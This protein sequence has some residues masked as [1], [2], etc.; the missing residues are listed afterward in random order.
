MKLFDRSFPAL[1]VELVATGL[2]ER[3]PVWLRAAHRKEAVGALE[4]VRA[5]HLAERPIAQLSGGELQ[6]VYL[7]RALVR[8]PRLVLLD[9]P[10]TGIDVRGEQDFYHLLEHYHETTQATILMVTH[11]WAAAEHHASHVLLLK[12]QQVAFGAPQA[13]LTDDHL[14]LAFGHAGHTHYREHKHA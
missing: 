1:A 9:E 2:L 6:R 5:A 4:R 8:E 13:V 11:D 10:A 3:W 12:T 14:N 7:A